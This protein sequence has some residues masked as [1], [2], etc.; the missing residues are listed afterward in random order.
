M[1]VVGLMSGT[2]HDGIDVAAADLRLDGDV[3]TL[4][5]LG[6]LAVEYA[7]E[8]RRGIVGLLPPA[9]TTAAAV[10]E[11]DTAV[12][13]A[14]ADA[15]VRAVAELCDGRADLVVS[16]G[17][18][19]FHWVEGRTVH[20]TLQLGQPAWVAE[21]TGLPVVADVRTRDVAAGG[22]GAPLVSMLDVLLLGRSPDA[23]R[24][25]LNLGGI[26]N[27]TVVRPDAAPVAFDTGPA[28]ALV[29]AAM[30]ALTDGREAY[31]ADGRRAAAG[32]V[33]PALLDRLLAHPYYDLAPPKTTGK[34]VF[35]RGYLDEVLA[36]AG[37]V[38]DDDLV[39][40]LT[41]LTA[42]TVADAAT[43]LGVT[44]VVAAGGGTR[45]PT[46]MAM[47]D[48]ALGDARL[49]TIDALGI[50][51]GAKEAHAFALL[52][53]LTVHGLP[54]TVP[55]CTGARHA[56]L[57]GAVLPGADGLPRVAPATTAPTRLEVV[58]PGAAGET[59]SAR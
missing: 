45:N 20:G 49:G 33:D 31:D 41:A 12:G 35:H 56:S 53:F 40:T 27:L 34:E 52:G 1:R 46:L 29:D 37:D 47:L 11:V 48:D 21:A 18:T 10:C 5:P 14:F 57:L 51:P 38:T 36:D 15:A 32:T 4:A 44:E 30:V 59:G 26:A 28:N 58:G 24:A 16:H 55:S 2:S 43:S 39:A 19:V 6:H 25:M 17:Q 3:V 23:P 42:R 54:A 8:V 50:D 13:Q 7:P 22:Q 9:S